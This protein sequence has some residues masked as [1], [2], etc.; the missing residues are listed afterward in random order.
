MKNTKK[1]II[2]AILA[3]ALVFGCNCTLCNKKYGTAT[4]IPQ[5]STALQQIINNGKGTVST[6]GRI[7]TD[8]R[9]NYTADD[10][11]FK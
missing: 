8:L 10:N 5:I 6:I 11:S 3:G 7:L 9:T 4:A 1:N 2:N